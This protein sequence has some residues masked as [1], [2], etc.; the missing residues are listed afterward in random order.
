MWTCAHRRIVT[1]S[2][3][4]LRMASQYGFFRRLLVRVARRLKDD[5]TFDIDSALRPGDLIGVVIRRATMAL[6]G[7]FLTI[8]TR[9]L[10]IPVFIGR[11]VRVTG[12]R[13]LTLSPGVTIDDY[14]RLDCMGHSG[15]ELGRGVTLR[16]GAQIEVTGVL[17]HLGSG[18]VV[19]DRVGIS[20]G[21]F[22][23]A[24]GPVTIGADT[25]IGP[26]THII[27]ENH[28]FTD[29]DR[30]IQSQG[31]SR[32]GIHIGADCWL[33]AHVTV[34]DGVSIGRGTVVGAGAVVNRDIDEYSIA[35]GMPARVQRSR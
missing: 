22:V 14:C 34:L 8:R 33:G 2:V 15:I 16:R 3:G 28:V 7:V 31:V 26:G 21:C 25:I 17:R 4:G 23:A 32:E 11:G 27:A 13:H 6:R 10:V 24:K 12:A 19:A 9:S 5:E 18:I 20:E 29:R 30:S 1:T 35:V